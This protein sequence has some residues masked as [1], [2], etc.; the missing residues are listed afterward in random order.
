M[1]T[2]AISQPSCHR[3][4]NLSK[5]T[6]AFAFPLIA[7]A[8]RCDAARYH[9]PQL[10]L[11]LTTFE[12]Q[13]LRSF[14]STCINVSKQA[15]KNVARIHPFN[16]SSETAPQGMLC[17]RISSQI[18]YAQSGAQHTGPRNKTRRAL[19][20]CP[21]SSLVPQPFCLVSCYSSL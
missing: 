11:Y 2:W 12:H 3:V 16:T 4:I 7:S 17:T 14:L 20:L 19:S 10:F 18:F 8:V 13:A 6:N 15:W 21:F 5:C 9:G 1:G